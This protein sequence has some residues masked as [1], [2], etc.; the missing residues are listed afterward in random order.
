[1]RLCWEACLLCFFLSFL[2]YLDR[3][4][5]QGS[6]RQTM[7]QGRYTHCVG[8][9]AKRSPSHSGP[10]T[11]C[12]HLA[13][14][15]CFGR[16]QFKSL[17]PLSRTT[18]QALA[19]PAFLFVPPSLI[20]GLG[21]TSY[22]QRPLNPRIKNKLGYLLPCKSVLLPNYYLYFSSCPNLSGLFHLVPAKHL[23]PPACSR[24]CSI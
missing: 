21:T 20:Q 8:G 14:P 6:S 16:K 3:M 17:L 11:C 18:A 2:F 12:G 24:G 5:W 10:W 1:M 23:W 13:P 19:S 4:W 9:K 22:H 15:T 7:G